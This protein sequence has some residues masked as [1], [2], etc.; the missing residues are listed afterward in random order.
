M[1]TQENNL[2]TITS[3]VLSR[4]FAYRI[5][6]KMPKAIKIIYYI[7]LAVTLVYWLYRAI[8]LTLSLIQRIGSFVFE[9]R[10]YY[11]FVICLIILGIG[12]LLASQFIFDLDP[13]GRVTNWFIDQWNN[14]RA[15]CVKIIGG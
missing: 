5:G 12:I 3:P 4:R 8:S 1:E 14:F 9:K 11:T 13:V 15:W 6:D 2:T 7:I 10:N